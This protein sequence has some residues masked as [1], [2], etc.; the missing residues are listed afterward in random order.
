MKHNPDDRRDNVDKIQQSI[1]NTIEN[2]ESTRDVMSRTD[3]KKTKKSLQE[4]NRR[5]EEALDGFRQEIRDEAQ[6]KARGYE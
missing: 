1:D 5:R 6:D 2:I 4:K 3:S